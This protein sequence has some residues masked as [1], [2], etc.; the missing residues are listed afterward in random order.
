M[1]DKI[2]KTLLLDGYEVD[3]QKIVSQVA[4]NTVNVPAGSWTTASS[5]TISEKGLYLCRGKVSLPAGAST[6]NT[7]RGLRMTTQ[8]PGTSG[9]TTMQHLALTMPTNAAWWNISFGFY[10]KVNPGNQ[11]VKLE[12]YSSQ[13]GN[14]TSTELLVS[15]ILSV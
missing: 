9:I 12:A 1:A 11:D 5:I 7:A 2:L 14:N 13:A 4:T 10:N 6:G 3:I 15:R 8:A